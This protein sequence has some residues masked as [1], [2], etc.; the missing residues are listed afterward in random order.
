MKVIPTGDRIYLGMATVETVG[1]KTISLDTSSKKTVKEVAT[2]E[3]IGP[4][5]KTVQV[6]DKVMVKAWAVD[7]ITYEKKE[8]FF[9][10]ERSGGICAIIK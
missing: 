3:G 7:S 5:V 2:V 4:D 6:G 8:Y 1:G 9:V 10:L